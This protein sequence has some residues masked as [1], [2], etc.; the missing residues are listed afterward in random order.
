[1]I[2][3]NFRSLIKPKKIE[4]E[5]VTKNYGKYSI[6]PYEKGF[7]ITVGN[8]LRRVLLSSIE[9]SAVVGIRIDGV[10]HEYAT[11][12]GVLE[13]VVDIILNVKSLDLK[14]H[15]HEQRKVR[16]E[17]KGEGNVTAADIIGD[18]NVEVLDGS[19]HI[20]TIT[21]PNVTLNMELFVERGVGYVPAED[22]K[23]KFDEV[24]IIPVDAVFAPI[25]KVNYT[26]D[27]ARVGHSTDYDK[28]IL[29]LETDG[30]INPEDAIA[31]AAKIIKDH[32]ELFIN[33]EEPE[34]EE[35]E[36]EVDEKN[37]QILELL[38]K[39]IE[40]LELS[41]RAYNCLKNAE[42]KTLAEL[43]SKTDA[44]MLKTKNFGRKSLE[45]IKKV[46]SELGLSLGMDLESIGYTE[47]NESEGEE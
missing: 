12:P 23:E 21:D 4:Q 29:E 20:A 31:F 7:G 11:I 19:Q 24:D 40:E 37:E 22:M 42:I 13:D 47:K 39:S 33:F 5:K 26:V 30:S 25:R 45:E 14:L 3:M 34:Y 43:C 38:D 28:L 9:G 27:N 1:M 15:T 17:K 46:L 6:E 35:E 2:V 16:I 8:A 36:D 44:E 10:N 32:M 41:V 18:P